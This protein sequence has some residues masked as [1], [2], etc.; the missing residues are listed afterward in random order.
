MIK[1]VVYTIVFYLEVGKVVSHSSILLQ[2]LVALHNHDFSLGVMRDVVTSIRGVGGVDA[3]SDGS[4]K[5]CTDTGDEPLRRVEAQ[6]V[7]NLKAANIEVLQGL[8]EFSAIIVVLFVS[9]KLPL[10]RHNTLLVATVKQFH[11]EQ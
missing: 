9:P 1:Y 7:N 5:D 6:D 2:L 8:G 4:G 10:F 11:K 3:S